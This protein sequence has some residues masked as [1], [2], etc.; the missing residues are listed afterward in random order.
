VVSPPVSALTAAAASATHRDVLMPTPTTAKNAATKTTWG[1]D[2]EDKRMVYLKDVEQLLC[3]CATPGVDG[4]IIKQGYVFQK[5]KTLL[6]YQKE[7]LTR[8]NKRTARRPFRGAKKGRS[9]RPKN[10]RIWPRSTG[11]NSTPFLS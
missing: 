10:R 5:L 8:P 9:K 7:R 2:M 4:G 1:T 6:I 11:K 3:D